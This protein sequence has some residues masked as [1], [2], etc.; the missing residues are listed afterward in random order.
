MKFHKLWL[1]LARVLPIT[2]LFVLA[3]IHFFPNP[4]I[5]TYFWCAVATVSITAAVTWWWW[6]MDTV[7]TFMQLVDRQ[8]QKFAEVT[9]EIKSVRK[10]LN[11]VK[12]NSSSR[13]RNKP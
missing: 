5:V 9:D 12:K 3:L 13:K 11:D 2:A 8:M 10:D 1:T 4:T 6:I 7:R